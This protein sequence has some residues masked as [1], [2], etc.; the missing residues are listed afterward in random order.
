[1]GMRTISAAS[2]HQDWHPADVIAALHK[3]NISLRQIALKHGYSHINRVLSSPWLGAEKLVAD[4]LGMRPEEI[5][6]TRYAD[7]KSRERAAR[8]TRKVKIAKPRKG[9]VAA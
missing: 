1:M 2:A 5:W 9:A 3:R 6:P 4:A 7:P 8:L